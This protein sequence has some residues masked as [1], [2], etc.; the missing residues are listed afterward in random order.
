MNHD[1]MIERAVDPDDPS[2]S[3]VHLCHVCGVRR[4]SEWGT[5]PVFYRRVRR[6]EPLTEEPPCG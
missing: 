3:E 2:E 4:Y 5:L 6:G 1:W